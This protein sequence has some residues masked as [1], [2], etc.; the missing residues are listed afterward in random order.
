MTFNVS[1]SIQFKAE[2]VHLNFSARL[3]TMKHKVPGVLNVA[4]SDT[5]KLLSVMPL[6]LKYVICN[7]VTQRAMIMNKYLCTFSLY[8]M[9]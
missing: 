1:H 9:K 5:N 2:T 3:A 8:N 4:S 7:P 6:Q